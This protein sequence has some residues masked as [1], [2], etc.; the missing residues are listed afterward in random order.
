M[1]LIPSP[2]TVRAHSTKGDGAEVK[3]TVLNKDGEEVGSSKGSADK[4][5]TFDVE[6]P[7]LWTPDSPYL[8]DIEVELGED[9]FTSYTGFRTV[10]Q[11]TIDGVIRPLL[12]GEFVFWFGTLDQGYWPDGLHTPPSREAM[13]YDLKMLKSL[14]F[15]MLRKHVS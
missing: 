14:G 9:H 8:Y 7:E 15:N 12:N 10:S 11:G 2:V 1:R 3:I 6:S 5:F 4:E 13:V